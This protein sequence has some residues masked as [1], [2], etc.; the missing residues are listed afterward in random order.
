MIEMGRVA[1]EGVLRLLDDQEP[2]LPHFPADLVIRK[3][4]I[5]VRQSE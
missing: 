3:S 5:R 4:A 1:A 2:M